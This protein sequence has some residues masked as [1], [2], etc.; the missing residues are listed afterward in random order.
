VLDLAIV[1]EA[2]SGNRAGV[3]AKTCWAYSRPTSRWVWATPPGKR[4][5]RVCSV[6]AGGADYWEQASDQS[7]SLDE[8][9][10][11]S[12]VVAMGIDG[13]GLDDLLGLAVLG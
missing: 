4:A 7:L 3:S 8:L 5:S 9:L 1:I 6:V 12:E 2:K 13:G 10:A 11:R